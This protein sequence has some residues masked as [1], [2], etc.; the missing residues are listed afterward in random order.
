MK[1][2]RCT[3]SELVASFFRVAVAIEEVEALLKVFWLLAVIEEGRH[4][5]ACCF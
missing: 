4:F 2:S 5:A 1:S 3:G